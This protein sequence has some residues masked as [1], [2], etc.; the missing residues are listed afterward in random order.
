MQKRFEEILES[1]EDYNLTEENIANILANINSNSTDDFSYA[2]NAMK[3]YHNLVSSGVSPNGILP[4]DILKFNRDELEPSK[5][6]KIQELNPI[7]QEEIRR[8]GIHKCPKCK[9]W[10]TKHIQLQTRSADEGMSVKCE[11]TDCNFFWKI[12]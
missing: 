10:Y 12:S 9:S 2:I 7:N 1:T 3:I 11:C 8:K 4:E 5:W 6:Q